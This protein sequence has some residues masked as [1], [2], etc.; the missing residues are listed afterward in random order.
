[1]KMIDILKKAAAILCLEADG[2]GTSKEELKL[3]DCANTVYEELTTEYV[4]LKAR[5][6]TVFSEG[7]AHYSDFKKEVRD[8]IAVYRSG[9][10]Q[11]FQMFPEYIFAE[12]LNGSAEV[13]YV[14]RE[15]KREAE[16]ELLLPPQFSSSV[17]AA[18]TA[19]EYC[20]RSGLIDEGIF[21]KNR[22]DQ[23][24]YNLTRSVKKASMPPR[25]FI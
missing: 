15:G 17:V 9:E 8:V 19:A 21:Y 12:G 11:R 2:T 20:Y 23:S 24:V 10:R 5:E 16:D 7:Q 3:L 1:M 4:P 14:F 25:R 6:E 18:G 22:Y 13:V